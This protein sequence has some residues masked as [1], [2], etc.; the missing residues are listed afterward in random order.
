MKKPAFLLLVYGLFAVFCQCVF[1]LLFYLCE[2]PNISG[3]VLLHRYT[4]LLE[5]PLMSLS[6]LFGGGTLIRYIENTDCGT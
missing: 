1:L 2:A 3:E 5:Y 6:L 4:P